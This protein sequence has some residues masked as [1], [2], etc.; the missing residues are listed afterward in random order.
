[1]GIRL[2]TNQYDESVGEREVLLAMWEDLRTIRV[3]VTIVGLLAIPLMLL[4]ILRLA[5]L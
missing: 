5:Q 2:P 3:V 1:M 4:G